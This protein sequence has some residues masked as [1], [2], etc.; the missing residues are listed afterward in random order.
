M[1]KYNEKLATQS[2]VKNS[3]SNL[4]KTIN[5]PDEA[6]EAG[7]YKVI[8]DDTI[9]QFDAYILIVQVK[10][11]DSLPI[12]QT[13]LTSDGMTYSREFNQFDPP[14]PAFTQSTV[15]QN[16]MALFK[17]M[18]DS[19][20]ATIEDE[21]E[22]SRIINTAE[23]EAIV[24]PDSADAQLRGLKVMGKT[25]QFNTNGYQLF[26]AENMVFTN[27]SRAEY[28][29][30]GNG[31]I[32][33]TK[34]KDAGFTYVS[35]NMFDLEKVAG[36]K[37]YVSG[38]VKSSSVSSAKNTIRIGVGNSITQETKSLTGGET[39]ATGT[40]NKISFS[41][42]LAS[43]L[44][45]NY[46]K[47]RIILYEN[48]T[49]NA[50]GNVG[51]YV[52]FSNIMIST[53]NVEYEPYTGG[54]P[55]PN[56]NYPQPLE[57]VGDDGSVDVSICGKNMVDIHNPYQVLG[58]VSYTA[59]DGIATVVRGT[60]VYAPSIYFDLGKYRSWVGKTLTVSAT[61]QE[62]TGTNGLKNL[63]YINGAKGTNNQALII[64][65]AE[66]KS[67]NK[68]NSTVTI[69]ENSEVESL[70]IRLYLQN[71]KNSDEKAVFSNFQVELG[72][73]STSYEPY[74]PI[75]TLNI[76]TPNGL[77]AVPVSSD[78]NYTDASGQQW[79]C[80][81]VD[82]ARGVYVQR[83]YKYEVTGLEN[84]KQHSELTVDGYWRYDCAIKTPSNIGQINK[85]DLCMCTHYKYKASMSAADEGVWVTNTTSGITPVVGLRIVSTLASLDELTQM[86]KDQY[87]A[88]TPVTYKYILAE[89]IET[90]LSAEEIAAYKALHT[91]YPHTSIHN[92]KNAHMAVDYVAD[93]KN[94][95][96]NQIKKEVAE[97]TA[98][99]LTQ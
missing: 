82:F 31:V 52:D 65:A 39:E 58:G 81:E 61:M 10:P 50:V 41:C 4:M 87:S 71:L 43:D 42:N 62:D 79:V 20:F 35:G 75:Q 26:D 59:N 29:H 88:G 7:I 37:I 27:A 60:A 2:F 80:D 86:L 89:P 94:Y 91:H 23:G 6:I 45:E 33:V 76:P 30:M 93:T 84:W 53:E 8:D 15:S 25:E 68:V 34:T 56:V 36:K 32:R 55:A 18:V 85:I 49:S 9:A 66:F 70:R 13:K 96:D 90:P 95:V 99:I 19:Q 67:N 12:R 83:T 64:K 38:Y 63:I 57:S 17:I 11:D 40:L 74:K 51:D 72:E 5:N 3:I 78:G 97:L 92:S 46:D 73:A 1:S 44:L 22:K 77:P 28:K 16:D 21:L 48:G 24:L 14:F 54:V 69:P 98:A 47:V